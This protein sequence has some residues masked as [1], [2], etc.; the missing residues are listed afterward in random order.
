MDRKHY[1][2]LIKL[3]LKEDRVHKDITSNAVFADGGGMAKGYLIAK[4]ELVI[5]GLILAR[6]VFSEVSPDISF[7]T[8][9]N[10]GA[11]I[12]KGERI[13][14]VEGHIS[15]LLRAER[16]A[17]NFL[18]YLSGI[19]TLTRKFIQEVKP[20]P[21]KVM[22]TRKTM[23]GLRVL[24]KKA[25]RDGGGTNHRMDLSDMY[26]IKDNHIEACK[27]VKPAIQKVKAHR[28]SHKSDHPLLIEVEARNLNE[29]Q[30]ALEEGADM[31][32]LDNM[33]L[34][35]IRKAVKLAHG[36][37]LLEVSGGVNLKNVREIA[38]TGVQ[39]IS[40]GLLTHSVHA[41]DIA[42]DIE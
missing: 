8:A 2:A 20:Y 4:Q 32:L 21:C 26:I 22:G 38:K 34:P 1:K 37:C 30:I 7:V 28:R 11:V 5:S 36:R 9:Y 33:S 17:L 15:D 19:A 3:A 27:G 6:M 14:K 31:I 12:K 35:T 13:A 41:A 10:D 25:I 42:F 39:R 29:V 23:P 16:V 18:Q 40:I 24:A